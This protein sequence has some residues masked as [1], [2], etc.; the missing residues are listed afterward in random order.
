[1]RNYEKQYKRIYQNTTQAQCEN[2]DDSD[3]ELMNAPVRPEIEN[4]LNDLKIHLES[5]EAIILS[6]SSK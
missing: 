6:R 3:V 5:K 1:M 2:S 4:I